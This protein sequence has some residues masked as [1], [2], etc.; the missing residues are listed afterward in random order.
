MRPERLERP[1]SLTPA[2]ELLVRR[3]TA[4]IVLELSEGPHRF[5]ELRA[6]YPELPEDRLTEALRD[7]AAD[8]VVERR[9]DPGPP[10]R[11]VYELTASGQELAPTLGLL[12]VWAKRWLEEDDSRSLA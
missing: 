9:V 2:V 12:R 8:G 7:L 3:S 11:V 4:S 6:K 10:F 5:V 1:V